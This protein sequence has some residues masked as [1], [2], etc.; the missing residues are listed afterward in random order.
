MEEIIPYVFY[1]VV[2]TGAA[3]AFIK[4]IKDETDTNRPD[5]F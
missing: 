2:V 3:A 1:A 4:V 5:Q